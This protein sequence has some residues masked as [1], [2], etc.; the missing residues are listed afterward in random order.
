MGFDNKTE[1]IC[2]SKHKGASASFDKVSCA[3]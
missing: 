2:V 1:L 3:S